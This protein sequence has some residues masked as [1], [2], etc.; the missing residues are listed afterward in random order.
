MHFPPIDR[1]SRPAYINHYPL[2][3]QALRPQP[4]HSGYL[5]GPPAQVSPQPRPPPHHPRPPLPLPHPPPHPHPRY[6][7]RHSVAMVNPFSRHPPSS[8]QVLTGLSSRPAV[9]VY[10]HLRFRLLGYRPRRPRLSLRLS[11]YSRCSSF[12]LGFRAIL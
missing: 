2:H 11:F 1:T 10:S 6:V 7:L 3:Y 4:P 8:H 5:H 12:R 9:R